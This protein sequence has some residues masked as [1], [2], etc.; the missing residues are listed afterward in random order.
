VPD[1]FNADPAEI[2][3]IYAWQN[4]L[5]DVTDVVETQKSQ[6]SDTALLSAQCYNS[7]TKQRSY[8]GV[9]VVGFVPPNH[10]WKSL[11]EMAGYKMEDIPKTW[12]AY[13]DFFKGVQK[14]LRAHGMRKVYG[15]GFQ[16]T[17]NGV[18]PNTEWPAASRRPQGQ[19]RGDQGSDLSD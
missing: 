7:V 10:V 18:D 8:Y 6:Y 11:V 14:G 12:D 13:Y 15:L 5:V 9:P 3:A 16:L 19:E 1:L 4:K 2:V 17:T